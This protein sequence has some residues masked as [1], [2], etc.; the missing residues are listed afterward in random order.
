MISK[1][2]SVSAKFLRKPIQA[3]VGRPQC[4]LQIK[5]SPFG[6]YRHVENHCLRSFTC[7]SIS[8]RNC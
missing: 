3:S 7:S 4:S 5:L 1:V 8:W 2:K 6:M